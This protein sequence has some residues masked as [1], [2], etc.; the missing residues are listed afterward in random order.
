MM[1][2]WEYHARPKTY[3]MGSFKVV[4]NLCLNQLKRLILGVLKLFK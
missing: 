4:K 1:G 2:G 3:S